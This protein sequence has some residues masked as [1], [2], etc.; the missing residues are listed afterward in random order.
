MFIN[1]DKTF[2]FLD[3]CIEAAEACASLDHMLA[4]LVAAADDQKLDSLLTLCGAL[5]PLIA[6]ASE[7]KERFE[8]AAQ[9]AQLDPNNV[10]FL[11]L[12]SSPFAQFLDANFA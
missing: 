7:A 6:T 12:Y 9:Q 4:D 8:R 11:R 5:S 1:F 10:C 3:V 2:E